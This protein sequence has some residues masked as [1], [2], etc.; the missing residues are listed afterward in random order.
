MICG[1]AGVASIDCYGRS[2]H[3]IEDIIGRKSERLREKPSDCRRRLSRP[4]FV[5]GFFCF[6]GA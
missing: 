2:V 4:N 5:G 3:N 6:E 1:K